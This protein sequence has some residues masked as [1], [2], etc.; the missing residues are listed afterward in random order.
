[1]KTSIS[2][3]GQIVLPAEIRRQDGIEPREQFELERIDAGE[4]RLKRIKRRPNA[5]LVDALLACPVM[6]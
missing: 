3:K 4:Y 5:G 1:M 2:T 6:D